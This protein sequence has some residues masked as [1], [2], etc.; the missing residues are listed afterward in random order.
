MGVQHSVGPGLATD[1]ALGGCRVLGLV[2]PVGKYAGSVC[3]T[4]CC[5]LNE[6]P[7]ESGLTA[8]TSS[9]SPEE[10]IVD[11][12]VSCTQ[13]QRRYKVAVQS[14]WGIVTESRLC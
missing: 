2:H 7:S 14:C 6:L 12:V 13:Q 5:G 1:T 8:V 3:S 10:E 11:M 4:L 9:L